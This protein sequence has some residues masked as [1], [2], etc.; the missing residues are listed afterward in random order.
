[1]AISNGYITLTDLKAWLKVDPSDTA[2]DAIY[3]RAVEAASRSIDRFCGR[4]FY[5]DSNASQRAYRAEDFQTVWTHDI[6]SLTGLIVAVDLNDDGVFET[7][8]TRGPDY[9]VEPAYVAE[10]PV[11]LIRALNRC[12]RSRRTAGSRW[13]L[14]QSGVGLRSLPM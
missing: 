14:P 9:Q 7:T 3:E 11:V 13:G 4:R 10:R 5:L 6:G 12:F 2:D 1:M 8:W